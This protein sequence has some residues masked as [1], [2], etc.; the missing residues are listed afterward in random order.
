MAEVC[1]NS[2]EGKG[3]QNLCDTCKWSPAEP[4][5]GGDWYRPSDKRARFPRRDAAE[6]LAR[7]QKI[8]AKQASKQGKDKAR[9]RIGRKA[10]R[11]EKQTEKSIIK[12]TVNSGR[13]HNDGDHISA[14]SIVLDTKMQSTRQ[15][16]VVRLEELAKV[17]NQARLAGY[18]IGAL[19]LRN[20]DGL[21]VVCMAEADFAVLMKERS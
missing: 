3:S 21:G 18:P 11:A 8:A 13:S 4:D 16:P 5:M 12:S 10:A 19:V 9:T 1:Q 6:Y 17:R 20:K 2:P 14:G 15:H 7:R